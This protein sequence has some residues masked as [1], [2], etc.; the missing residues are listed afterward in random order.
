MAVV[1]AILH[2][3]L[4]A[5]RYYTKRNDSITIQAQTHRSKGAN[6]DENH[7]KLL[8]EIRRIYTETIPGETSE[9]SQLKHEEM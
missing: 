4:R 7:D 1:P 2:S 6:A 8:E 3:G 9:D 5:S